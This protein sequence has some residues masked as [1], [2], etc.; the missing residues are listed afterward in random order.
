MKNKED[1]KTKFNKLTDIETAL[2]IVEKNLIKT[3]AYEEVSLE[4]C[5]GRILAENL[6]SRYDIPNYDNA[7][8][9]GF[10]F[11][12]K[13]LKKNNDEL[14]IANT[15]KPGKPFS[16]KIKEGEAMEIFT[17]SYIFKEKSN[18]DTVVMHEDCLVKKRKVK[19]LNLPPQG[20][21]IRPSGED[22]KKGTVLFR[23][24][25]KLR[26]IDLGA[27]A[28][29]G[30]S[31]IKVYKK[32]KVGIFSTG[33]EL[34]K[35]KNTK[36]KFKIFD[37]NKITLISLFKKLNC[38]TFDFGILRDNYEISKKKLLSSASKVDII[39]TTGG[40]ADSQSDFIVKVLNDIGELKLW[41]I[42]VKPGRPFVFGKIN[43]KPIFGLPGNP[44]AV[45]VTFFMIILKFLNRM[46]G[47][48]P[49]FLK[50]RLVPSGFSFKKKL[51]R[52]EWLRGSI[53]FQ[54]NQLVL[55]KFK[56]EGS[57]ILSS[58]IRSEGIIE[59]EKDTHYI[60]KGEKI[61]FYNFEELLN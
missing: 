14:I 38:I 40:V 22:I 58:I 28:S 48:D 27:I 10:A 25:T 9:D 21:N 1:Y 15:S 39:I 7:A 59:I 23:K 56:S 2:K 42:S 34:S 31:K 57:G 30:I 43:K 45:V 33:N 47:R 50:Y 20:S 4:V 18:V 29:I 3:T 53:M 8:V 49:Y 60:E 46:N 54:N 32:I 51:G 52:T 12:F 24:G 55:K 36:D 13:N 35:Y 44:V 37:S 5:E 19:I 17:G 41:R 61:K 6:T 16:G 11:N 26:S